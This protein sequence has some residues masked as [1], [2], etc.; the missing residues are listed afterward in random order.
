MLAPPQ[1]ISWDG[2]TV[3]N[4]GTPVFRLGKGC[5][6][7]IEEDNEN[8]KKLLDAAALSHIIM[9]VQKTSSP[10]KSANRQPKKKLKNK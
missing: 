8:I 4:A 9:Q 2:A 6:E 1:L 5:Y 3:V 10:C 7:L